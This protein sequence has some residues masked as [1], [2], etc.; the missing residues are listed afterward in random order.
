MQKR[1]GL[2]WFTNDLRLTD[3]PLLHKA[4]KEVDQLIC[5]YSRPQLTC[6]LQKY[7][8]QERWGAARTRFLNQ[9]IRNLSHSLDEFGQQLI[10]VDEPTIGAL[11]DL[12]IKH[13]VSD[14]YCNQFAGFDEQTFIEQL[15][16]NFTDLIIHQNSSNHL[17]SEEQLPFALNGLPNTFTKFRKLVEGISLRELVEV[18]RLPPP[19]KSVG[20]GVQIP[21]EKQMQ[22]VEFLGGEVFGM[23]HCLR[24]FSTKRASEYKLTRNG[25]DG[26]SYSTKF[27]P[28]LA[29][30]C[31][32]PRQVLE[33]L[34]D[35]EQKNGANESTYWIFFEL[36]WR[37]FFYWYA[38][39]WGKNLFLYSGIKTCSKPAAKGTSVSTAF[40]NW[41]EGK[42]DFPIVN[43]CMNQLRKTGFMSNRG[44]QLV[45]SCL[46]HELGIDWRCGAAYFETQLIDYDVG[47]NWGNWQYLAGVGADTQ[48]GRQF[49]L[50]KQTEIYDPKR[51]FIM[52]WDGVGSEKGRLQ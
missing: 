45:A 12:V 36:L 40:S 26:P 21:A 49:N 5:L 32:S 39:K 29:H 34:R 18:P 2:Y 4:S 8:C 30:G 48:P 24:Y 35:Y 7:S 11:S 27:S 22:S 50:G 52:Q 20:R 46:I 10:V 25:L 51:E 6:F 47:S 31:I 41:V 38:R 13:E 9:S 28:W 44:R 16:R 15:G 17:Y 14:L 3:N 37:E 1:I 33:V 19:I 23:D 42:T 43:A